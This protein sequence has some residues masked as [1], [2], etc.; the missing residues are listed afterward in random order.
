MQKHKQKIISYWRIACAA[1]YLILVLIAI[2][3]IFSP[4]TSKF[5]KRRQIASF[6]YRRFYGALNIQLTITGVPTSK[7]SLWVCNHISWLDILLLAGNN[8]VDFIAKT[9]VGEWPIVGYIIRKSGTLLISRDNKFQAY[10]SLP[11]LQKRIKTSIPVIVFPEGTTTD[12]SST[13]PFK[14]MFYQ[15]AIREKVMIQPISLQYFDE[16]GELSH[17][18]A[19]IDDDDFITSLKRILNQPK[20]TAELHFLPAVSANEYHRK[21]LA[22]MNRQT[23]NDCLTQ[24][25]SKKCSSKKRSSKGKQDFE[26]A[27]NTANL[28]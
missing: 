18:V 10:R 5:A 1:S 11:L 6:L 26:H 23:I 2:P 8:T 24:P 22:T 3:I 17:C 14:P 20:I 28:F 21:H 13:L 27:T 4:L 9:E 19:F 7:P 12:G 15:A 25:T 16:S